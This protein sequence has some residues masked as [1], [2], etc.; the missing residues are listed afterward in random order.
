MIKLTDLLIENMLP[1]PSLKNKSRSFI[2]VASVYLSF[3]AKELSVTDL[4]KSDWTPDGCAWLY[5][6]LRNCDDSESHAFIAGLN[7]RSRVL[8]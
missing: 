5:G 8:A 6:N 7:R 2:A 1:C 4:L 3:N